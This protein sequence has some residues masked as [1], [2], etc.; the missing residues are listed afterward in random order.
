M[1]IV[2]TQYKHDKTYVTPLTPVAES[3]EIT[4]TQPEGIAEV[5]WR[6]QVDIYQQISQG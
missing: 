2:R 5:W 4:A 6:S 1:F 3:R